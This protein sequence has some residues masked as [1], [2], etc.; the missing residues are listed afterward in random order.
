MLAR[1]VESGRE[2]MSLSTVLE[3]LKAEADC[4]Q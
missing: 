1:A 4:V 2:E 3:V